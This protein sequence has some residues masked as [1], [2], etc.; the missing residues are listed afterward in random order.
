[1]AQ[2]TIVRIVAQLTIVRIVAQLTIVRIVAQLTIF[3][4]VAQMT[5]FQIVEA[6]ETASQNCSVQVGL[7]YWDDQDQCYMNQ[8][9]NG[10]FAT[11]ELPLARY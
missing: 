9:V 11:Q 2:L 6:G 10:H 5:A 4:I 3:L 1:M 7:D 8:T